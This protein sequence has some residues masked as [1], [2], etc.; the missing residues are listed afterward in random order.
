[1]TVMKLVWFLACVVELCLGNLNVYLT[2]WEVRRL[3][4]KSTTLKE[5]LFVYILTAFK[6][7]A[8]ITI[9]YVTVINNYTL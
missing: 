3:L 9:V 8:K 6:E 7:K 5:G 4:G 1:M 2:Q